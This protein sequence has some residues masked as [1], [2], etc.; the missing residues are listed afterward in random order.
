MSLNTV[1]FTWNIQDLAQ[2]GLTATMSLMP[3]APLTDSTD[4]LVIGQVARSKDFGGGIGQIQ[5]VV[6]CDD[7][8][9][10]PAGWAY[11]ITVKVNGVPLAGYP[12]TA[13]IN[14]A[15]AVG[16]AVDLSALVPLSAVPAL[17]AV[18]VPALYPAGDPTGVKD[19]ANINGLLNL[20]ARKVVLGPGQFWVNT[21][22]I[23]GDD[24]WVDGSGVGLTYISPAA[25]ANCDV[26]QGAG[27]GGLT[28]TGAN[29]V[30]TA[31]PRRVQISNMT[32]DGNRSAQTLTALTNAACNPATPP[33]NGYGIRAFGRSWKLVNLDVRNCFGYGGWT[34]WGSGPGSPVSVDGSVECQAINVKMYENGVHGWYHRGPSDCQFVNVLCYLNNQAGLNAGLDFWAEGDNV[35]NGSGTSNFSP[36]GLQLVNV[37]CWGSTAKWNMVLDCNASAVNCHA[38]GGPVGACLQRGNIKWAGGSNYFI[39]SQTQVTGCGVQFG[40]AGATA[41][42]PTTAA[43][44]V[45]PAYFGAITGVLADVAARAGMVWANANQAM[46]K[47]LVLTKAIPSA[48]IAAGSNGQTLPQP[49]I[50]YSAGPS[51]PPSGTVIIQTTGGPDTVTYTG[52]TGSTL[53]GCTGGT[54]GMLT[55]QAITL[56][57][58]GT[59]AVSGTIDSAS[60]VAIEVGGSGLVAG[61]AQASSQH[62]AKGRHRIDIGAQNLGFNVTNGGADAFNVNSNGLRVE[63]PNG[64]EWRL[65]SDAYI[66]PTMKISGATAHIGTAV[67]AGHTITV[68][69]AAGA[70]T[71]PPA[72]TLQSGAAD[73]QGEVNLGTGTGPTSGS[74]ATVTYATAFGAAPVVVLSP[75]N[76]ATAALQP[77]ISNPTANG[78]TIAFGVAPA[79]SQPVGT[80]VVNY[81]V[82]AR[83]N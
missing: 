42:V 27:F 38:E 32:I 18:A 73:C 20:G 44:T 50:F 24:D 59:V 46:V 8:Q 14:F 43:V 78:F 2:S 21:A 23:V 47:A 76:A 58:V 5:G 56:A 81:I 25:A 1:N 10:S 77:Y 22:V 19:A 49:T 6:C 29:G 65:Y 34:E 71:T 60:D 7:A 70:G 41:G 74:Q 4:N 62:F 9:I 75:V 69:A 39:A 26:F 52:N 28:G 82:I 15:D 79:A 30:T 66:T 57:N 55:G 64:Y 61:V 68:A 80:Y 63:G 83:G 17:A 37:H 53:T 33:P 51:L 13:R 67:P 3:T 48:T 35:T 45:T 40:D 54:H 12:F 11:T 31:G 36:N 16:G 72:P